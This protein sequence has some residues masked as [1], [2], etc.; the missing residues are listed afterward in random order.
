MDKS[1]NMDDVHTLDESRALPDDWSE[2]ESPDHIVEKYDPRP[3]TLFTYEGAE[4]AVHV[5]PNEPD[6]PHADTHEYRVAFVRGSR[7]EFESAEPFALAHEFENGVAVAEVFAQAFDEADGE[8][9]AAVDYAME[10]AKDA[11]E[12]EPL[13]R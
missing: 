2:V 12:A 11:P 5:V 9:E 1:W 13:Q 3:V 7:D 6:H 10:Q 4:I 8:G